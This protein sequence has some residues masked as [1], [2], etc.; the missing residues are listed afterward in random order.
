MKQF[1]KDFIWG[2][3]ASS[4]QIEGAA[5]VGGR[6]ESIWD[7]F[8]HTPGK[9]FNGETG[10]VACDHYH[11][12]EN[13]VKLMAELGVKSY[14]FSIAWPR[15]LPRGRGRVNE[16]G[17]DF[18]DR[19]VDKL[20]EAGIDPLATLYHWDLP[21]AL[22]DEGG[23]LNR[24]TA[25]HFAHYTDVVSKRLGDRIKMWGTINEPICVAMLGYFTGM[26]APGHQDETMQEMNTALHHLLLGHGKAVRVLRQNVPDAKVGAMINIYPIYPATE[27]EEDKAAAERFYMYHNHWFTA[28]MYTGEYP[29]EGLRLFGRAT[30]DIQDGDMDIISTPTDYIGLNYYSRLIAAYDPE[31][32]KPLQVKI[33]KEPDVEY[34]AMDWEVFPDGLHDVLT[35]IYKEYK[36]KEIIIAEN[37]CAVNDVV[38]EDGKVIDPQRVSYIKRHIHAMQKTMQEGVPVKGY[39]VWSLMDNFE[40]SYGFSKRFGIIYVDYETQKRIPKE[41]YYTYQKIVKNNAIN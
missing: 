41:S 6:G 38:N 15:I 17:L 40:W 30:P 24:E 28:A 4:Y 35:R 5:D 16:A 21:Q 8:S 39:Y 32:N 3:A 9:T 14:R 19:L 11:L 34:T 7:R 36:P 22:D 33:V 12:Y 20:I 31:A 10:D 18:Y 26:H 1:P 2:V 25:D 37:G 29:A 27:A 23:W 13:D